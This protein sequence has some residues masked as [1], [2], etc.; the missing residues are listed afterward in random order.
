MLEVPSVDEKEH[1]CCT[2]KIEAAWFEPIRKF[3]LT[4]LCAEKEER[5]MRV[6]RSRFTMVGSE[7]YRRGY[8]RPLLKCI[9][10]EEAQYVLKELHLGI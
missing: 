10:N 1:V 3:L 2:S 7:L 6:K 4:G 9:T 8:T 5:M